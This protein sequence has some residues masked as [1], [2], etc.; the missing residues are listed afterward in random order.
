MRLIACQVVDPLGVVGLEAIDVEVMWRGLYK[1]TLLVKLSAPPETLL[2]P[3]AK[4][5]RI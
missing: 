2:V 1:Q 3:L 4:A 5:N